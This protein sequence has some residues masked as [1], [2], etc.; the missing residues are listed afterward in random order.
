MDE[1][2]YRETRQAERR[3]MQE[4]LKWYGASENERMRG[5]DVDKELDRAR[6]REEKRL[7]EIRHLVMDG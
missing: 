4:M 2:L 3:H 6:R 7:W 5:K 1:D